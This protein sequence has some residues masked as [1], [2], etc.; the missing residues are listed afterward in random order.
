MVLASRG[1]PTKYEKG[2]SLTLPKTKENEYIYVAGAAM[3][4]GV[5]KTNGGRVVG[6]AV[7]ADTLESAI[8]GA[9]DLAGRI[10]FDNAYCRSD[11][12]QRALA[13]GKG[14]NR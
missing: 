4:D 13:A 8:A 14:G 2:F 5:L 9:Y 7:V 3:E 12:G 10:H 1:Y 11:I 6:A